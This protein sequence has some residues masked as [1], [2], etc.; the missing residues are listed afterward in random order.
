[1]RPFNN[2][3]IIRSRSTNSIK[4]IYIRNK[5]AF[6]HYI[7]DKLRLEDELTI[8]TGLCEEAPQVIYGGF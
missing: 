8:T 7:V 1:M 4:I 5:R 6:F 3:Y 2:C